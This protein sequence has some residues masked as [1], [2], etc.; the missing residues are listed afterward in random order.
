[1]SDS[2]STEKSRGI[3]RQTADGFPL[4][5]YAVAYLLGP[6]ECNNDSTN[7]WIFSDEGLKRLI[8]RT[9]WSILAYTTIGDK[10]N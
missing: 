3:A 8:H 9:G 7:F 1:L 5:K 4:S 2:G 10:T 6:E